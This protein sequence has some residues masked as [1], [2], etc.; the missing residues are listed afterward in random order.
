MLR[1]F[2]R[3]FCSEI[4]VIVGIVLHVAWDFG[5]SSVSLA[6]VSPML[7][8]ISAAPPA[9]GYT[10][11]KNGGSVAFSTHPASRTDQLHTNDRAVAD[12]V[13]IQKVKSASG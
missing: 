2:G 5:A 9:D 3:R 12:R 10:A 1:R 11:R 7:N 4:C 13:L 8:V 6:D